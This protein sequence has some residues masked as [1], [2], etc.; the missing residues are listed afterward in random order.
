VKAKVML[1]GP[2]LISSLPP[3]RA[4]KRA[5]LIA[6]LL[7]LVLFFFA[8]LFSRVQLTQIDVFIPIVAT[9]MLLTDSITATLLFAQ[10]SVLRSHALLVLASGYLFTALLVVPY[11]LTFPGAFA[12]AGLL[13]AGLQTTGWLFVIWHMGLPTTVIAYALL[14][15]ASAT[16]RTSRGSARLAILASIA[17]VVAL[18]CA[19]TWFVIAYHASLP[20]MMLNLT[21]A[22]GVW[23]YVTVIILSLCISALLLLW[24]WRRSML[25]LWLLVVSLAWLLD[26]I[27]LNFIDYRFTVA[28][29]ANRVFGITSASFVLFV[30]LSESTMLYAQL[31]ISVLAQRREREGRLVSMGAMSAAIAHEVKQ[32]LGAIV[33]NANAGLRWL[34]RTPPRVDRIR[35]TLNDIATE[36]HRASEV[37]QSVRAMFIQNDQAETLLNANEL[38]RETM[39]IVRGELKAGRIEVRLE[40]ASE[41]PLVPAHRGQLQQVL[42]NLVSNAADA[43]SSITDRARVLKVKSGAVESDRVAVLV[44]DSGTGIDP[45]YM[46]RLFDAFFTTKSNGMGM[47]LA[48][49]KSIVES[50]GGVLSASSATPHG[51]VFCVV[52]P[53][54]I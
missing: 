39:A 36:G 2:S 48:I 40:L 44:E 23:R 15:N 29:Y 12:P 43:M 37:I 46:N 32:P 1:E 27:L 50:H 7:L 26:S 25:D 18:V 49:C 17:G 5:A 30:L 19:L 52:L 24:R 28:W 21:D 10:F 54:H 8:A 42:L 20:I 45:K 11:A 33:A 4:H 22:G 47:G 38:I 3:S 6:A 16:M 53:T 9:V 14:N 13:G 41:L 51:A 31:A 34:A 35:D